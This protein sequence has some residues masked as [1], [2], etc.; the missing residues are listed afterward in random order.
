MQQMFA[1]KKWLCGV[2]Q[3]S[4]SLDLKRGNCWSHYPTPAP[5]L[6][7]SPSS[8]TSIE[9]KDKSHLRMLR[10]WCE[11]CVIVCPCFLDDCAERG[12]YLNT[13]KNKKTLC[14]Q[15]P[16]P[17]LL[18]IISP[19]VVLTCSTMSSCQV[20][21]LPH[22]NCLPQKEKLIKCCKVACGGLIWGTL[23]CLRL[24]HIYVPFLSACCSKGLQ[25]ALKIRVNSTCQNI[26][27]PTAPFPSFEPKEKQFCKRCNERWK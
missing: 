10:L 19:G 11:L 6:P 17:P 8:P 21:S 9:T 2:Q 5:H 7:T 15:T 16:Q 23:M 12:P 20:F 27:L 3:D 25:V 18:L 22:V 24:I 1:E 14:N 4:C 26:F 13:R